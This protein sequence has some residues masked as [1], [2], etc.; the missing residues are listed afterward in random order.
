MIWSTSR[1]NESWAL[2]ERLIAYSSLSPVALQPNV[3]PWPSPWNVFRFI[4]VTRSRTV[5][6]TPYTSDQ[7]VA[8]SLL[9]APG[10][11]DDGEVGGMNGFGRG[12]RSTRRKP[13]PTP[14][15]P[16]QIPLARPG[17]E[18]GPPGWEEDC[19][20]SYCWNLQT[21]CIYSSRDVIKRF[22]NSPEYFRQRLM[23]CCLLISVSA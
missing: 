16:K 18:L 23:E 5:G 10:D 7:L 17:R 14:L 3:G 20:L 4:S 15:C 22:W 19:E 9:T 11:C 6:R 13:A 21:D 2:R 12:N 1:T 8:R